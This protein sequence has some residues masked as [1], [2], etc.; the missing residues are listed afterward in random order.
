MSGRTVGEM[1]ATLVSVF[2]PSVVAV[3]GTIATTG[4]L[5][6]AAVRE[7]VYRRSLPLATRDLRVV[8]ASADRR[9]GIGGA[10]H[11]IA[12]SVFDPE[13][14]TAWLTKGTPREDFTAV[15]RHAAH[16]ATRA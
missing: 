7:T 2:N 5:F 12:T 6:L 13:S 14:M 16:R 11:L 4:D 8:P 3:G 9:E 10:A 1:L 15:Y